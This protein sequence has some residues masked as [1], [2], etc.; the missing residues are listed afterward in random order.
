MINQ[1]ITAIQEVPLRSSSANETEYREKV[2]VFLA[3]VKKLSEELKIALPEVNSTF[4][5]IDTIAQNV[6]SS[7]ET[8]LEKTQIAI[9]KAEVATTSANSAMAY[10]DIVER[11]AQKV[12]GV[13][14]IEWLGFEI[15][16]S[17]LIVKIT[18]TS[19]GTPSIKNGDFIIA[20]N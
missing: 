7:K 10:A 6:E 13:A 11:N 2:E 5:T 14:S 9:D 15:I 20:Y 19:T 16:D 12:F 17:E 18:D 1:G 4:E 3:A 8:I